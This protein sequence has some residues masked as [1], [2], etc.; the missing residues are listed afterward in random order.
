[1]TPKVNNDERLTRVREALVAAGL[2]ALICRLPENVLMLSGHWSTVG[3]SSILFPAYGAPALVMGAREAVFAEATGWVEDVRVVQYG[4][5]LDTT[6]RASSEDVLRSAA[7]ELRVSRGVIGY[8]GGFEAVAPPYLAGL[9]RPLWP[10]WLA[11]LKRLLPEAQWVDATDLLRNLRTRKT[12]EEVERLRRTNRVAS[13]ALEAF[14]AAA[15]PGNTVGGVVAEVEGTVARCAAELG[16]LRAHA[17]AGVAAG[18]ATA[19][20]IQPPKAVTPGPVVLKEG[21]LVLLELGTVVDGYWSDTSRTVVAGRAS[22]RQRE[23]YSVVQEAQRR[24]ASLVHPGVTGGE[25]DSAARG[26]IERAGLGAGFC[27]HTGHGVGFVY[28]EE[29]L[30]LVPGSASCLHEGTTHV[31]EPGVY[32]PDWGGIRIEDDYAVTGS[33][34]EQLSHTS[35]ELD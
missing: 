32:I 10:G 15:L 34:V 25:V 28:I 27:H 7:D 6:P 33:G 8:E 2:D 14:K 26:V 23:V 9:Q 22:A 29:E 5:I 13:R 18:A 17:W 19:E 3:G 1:M 30:F 24:A 4:H 35:F 16:G 21:D 11:R 31:L 20:E 12:P